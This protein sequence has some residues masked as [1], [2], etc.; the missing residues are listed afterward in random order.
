MV[1]SLG[2][3]MKFIELFERFE[4]PIFAVVY[5]A[6]TVVLIL[7]MFYWRPF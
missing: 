6:A 3:R 4:K 5:A 7:D 2:D 1:A